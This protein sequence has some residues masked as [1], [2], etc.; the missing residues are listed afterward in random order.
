M[1]DFKIWYNDFFVYVLDLNNLK[2]GFVDIIIKNLNVYVI[3][4]MVYLF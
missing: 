3:N 2:F 1:D 4:V